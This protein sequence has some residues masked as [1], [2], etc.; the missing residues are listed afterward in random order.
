MGI[1]NSRVFRGIDESDQFKKQ[2]KKDGE[3]YVAVANQFGLYVKSI[4]TIGTDPVNEV[5]SDCQEYQIQ[6]VPGSIHWRPSGILKVILSLK[7]TPQP[8]YIFYSGEIFQI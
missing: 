6:I 8:H 7:I 3:K 1:I 2:V 5:L 4:W